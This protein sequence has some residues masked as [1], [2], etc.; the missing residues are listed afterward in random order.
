MSVCVVLDSGV[1]RAAAA[2]PLTLSPAPVAFGT[3]AVGGT[4]SVVVTAKNTGSATVVVE[5]AK[6]LT[7]PF[8][9]DHDLCHDTTLASGAT[10]QVTIVFSPVESGHYSRGLEIGTNLGSSTSSV[11]G[12]GVPPSPTTTTTIKL[13]A[14]TTSPTVPV[15]AVTT[16][17]LGST[18]T[19]SPQ[20]TTSVPSRDDAQRLLECER[21]AA[22]AQVSYPP[23]AKM[24]V[25]EID[26]IE[27]TASIEERLPVVS[28]PT[29]GVTN[30]T[31]ERV[32]LRCEVQALLRGE[33]FEID[34]EGYRDRTFLD[35]PTVP[36][37]WDVTPTKRGKGR[38]TLEIRSVAVIEGRRIEGATTKLYTTQIDV[39]VS[40][41]LGQ[42]IKRWSSNVVDH[43]L[44]QGFGGLLVVAGTVGGAWRWLLKRPW[45]WTKP[46]PT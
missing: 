42:K 37:T 32:A 40:E 44:V 16:T 15:S 1:E 24:T 39:G 18:V 29:T 36:W 21:R 34:P 4:K 33:D 25:G 19:T 22:D 7:A 20:T 10:C 28:S 11:I 45:P 8:L 9:V 5:G 26:Q 3:V 12:D 6:P 23:S 2:G 31:I 38:L 30:T 27:V 41:D 43:P 14:S 35:E 17:A 46:P 13:P